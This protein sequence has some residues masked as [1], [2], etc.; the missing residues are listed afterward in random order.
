LRLSHLPSRARETRG[1]SC[2]PTAHVIPAMGIA[3][4]FASTV[5]LRAESPI[6][7]RVAAIRRFLGR[8]SA[9]IRDSPRLGRWPR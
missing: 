9:C 7:G 3:H 4:G 1:G 5:I 8:A 6:F 2:G